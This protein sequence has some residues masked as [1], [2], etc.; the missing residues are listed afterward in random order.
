MKVKIVDYGVSDHPQ[1]CFVTYKITEID[2]K[3]I[4]KLKNSVEEE[5]GFKS[6]DMYLTA[7]FDKEYYPFA[8]EESKYRTED[9]IAREEIEMWAYLTSILED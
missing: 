8:S 3:S 7:Y 1:K 6:G 5:I 4:N 2:E 9:F